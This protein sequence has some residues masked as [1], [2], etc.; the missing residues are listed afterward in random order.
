MIRG[1]N[2]VADCPVDDAKVMKLMG[3]LSE[4]GFGNLEEPNARSGS[5]VTLAFFSQNFPEN[6]SLV[7]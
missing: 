2:A 5:I 1:G 3:A 7:D 4:G 6:F